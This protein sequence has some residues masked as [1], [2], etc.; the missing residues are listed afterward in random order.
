[1]NDAVRIVTAA[2]P[3]SYAAMLPFSEN[4]L[5]RL[6]GPAIPAVV[7]L[8]VTIEAGEMGF[9][10]LRSSQ[11]EISGERLVGAAEKRQRVRIFVPDAREHVGVICRNGQ[12]NDTVSTAYIYSASVSLLL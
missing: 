10:V 11:Q 7:D 9:G 8:E 2:A 12:L 4:A 1:V 5:A 3:W 6:R